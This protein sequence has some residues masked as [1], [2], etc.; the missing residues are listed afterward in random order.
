M[1]RNNRAG[2]LGLCST[3]T[4]IFIV[5]RLVGVIEWPWL[6]VLAPS[7]LPPAVLALLLIW[8]AK[9]CNTEDQGEK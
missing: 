8:A 1:N 5:L 7:W 3:L 6:W 9:L 2:G 4:V